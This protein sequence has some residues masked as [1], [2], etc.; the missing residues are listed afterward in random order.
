M[1]F[2]GTFRFSR[3]ERARRGRGDG[4]G[5]GDGADAAGARRGTRARPQERVH[6]RAQ[7]VR[8]QAGENMIEL[9]PRVTTRLKATT[10]SW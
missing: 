2:S 8:L 6:Q 7:A 9:A 1:G 4:W 10:R 3:S 5:E